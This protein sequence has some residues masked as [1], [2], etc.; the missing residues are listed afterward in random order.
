M[1]DK[2]LNKIKLKQEVSLEL[3]V[4]I[5]EFQN[6]LNAVTNCNNF[7]LFEGFNSSGKLFKGK[8][9]DNEIIIR[10]IK[11]LFSLNL[12]AFNSF[13]ASYNELSNKTV[14][15]GSVS[16]PKYSILVPALFFVFIDIVIGTLFYIL[17]KP[18]IYLISPVLCEFLILLICY[19]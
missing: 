19:L 12:I 9:S 7:N 10:P 2:F 16:Y 14:V 3:L 4:N 1:N 15:S 8:I 13:K 6:K 17:D 18:L 11:Q 5:S